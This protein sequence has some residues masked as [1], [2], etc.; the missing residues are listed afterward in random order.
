[1]YLQDKKDLFLSDLWPIQ[2]PFGLRQQHHIVRF[3][4]FDRQGEIAFI[5]LDYVSGTT[6]RRRLLKHEGPLSL[7]ETT[8]ILQ[9]VGGALNYAHSEGFIHRDIK[10]GNVMLRDDGVALLADFGISRAMESATLTTVTAG[11]PAYMSP[12]QITGKSLDVRTDIYSL[13]VML[14][15]MVT[16][17]RPFTGEESGLTETSTVGRLR[18][19][20]LRLAPPDPSRFNPQASSEVSRVILRALAKRPDDRWP[21]VESM[22]NAW[23]S[24]VGDIAQRA[25]AWKSKTQPKSSPSP[26]SSRKPAS[27]PPVPEQ[28]SGNRRRLGGLIGVALVIVVL[29]C[30]V[31]LF[32]LQGILFGSTA[33]PK[34]TPSQVVEVA[35]R[36]TKPIAN[37]AG[38][39][40]SVGATRLAKTATAQA[41]INKKMQ[42]T[43]EASAQ[44]ATAVAL[45]DEAN[46]QLALTREAQA[47]ATSIAA[48]QTV[49]AAHMATE[50]AKQRKA[51]RAARQTEIAKAVK[52]TQVAALTATAQARPTDTPVPPT[53]PPEPPPPPRPDTENMVFIPAGEFIMG[54]FEDQVEDAAQSCDRESHHSYDKCLRW[55]GFAS[56]QHRV[57]LDDFWIDETEVTNAMFAVFLNAQGNQKEGGENWL[58]LK[59]NGK[60]SPILLQKKNNTWSPKKGYANHPVIYVSWYGARAYCEWVGKRLPTE[61]EWEKAARSEDGRLFPWGDSEPDCNEAQYDGCDGKTTRVGSHPAGAS[62]YGVQDMA[63]NVWEW[64]ADWFDEDY[65]QT[66]PA[67]NPTGPSA[68]PEGKRVYRGGAWRAFS[69]FL[70]STLRGNDPPTEGTWDKGFRCAYS[71]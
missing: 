63:G 21:D 10:P 20:H 2:K 8:R 19:A 65:Y 46:R 5:V 61:A 28:K 44:T 42:K 41:S 52:L 68:S 3:Y 37:V 45:E 54:L 55:H 17:R 60:K 23:N 33:T 50:E 38:T 9:Q 56:P 48:T 25:G 64:V 62:P 36:P 31:G 18:E 53:V 39:K 27:P 58:V 24:A 47:L 70:I 29:M 40:E 12:E 22:V 6:L 13:G 57:Y 11:T 7:E 30:V 71:P 67:Q 49:D 51:T 15:Q 59:D 35:Q 43:L 32:S 4:S 66:S 14:Y 69:N 26:P 34:V 1:M 16:G